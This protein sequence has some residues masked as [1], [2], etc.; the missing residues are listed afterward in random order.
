MTVVHPSNSGSSSTPA[1]GGFMGFIGL[2]V[3]GL[4]LWGFISALRILLAAT[5]FLMS[6]A[7]WDTLPGLAA[8]VAQ[9]VFFGLCAGVAVA[10][11]RSTVKTAAGVESFVS[12]LFNRRVAAPELDAHFFGQVALT[13]AIGIAVGYVTGAAGVTM[14]PAAWSDASAGVLGAATPIVAFAG[15]GFGGPGPGFWGV[16]MLILMI[17][18]LTLI[19]AALSS[20]LLH[21]ILLGM[22][23]AT[24]GGVRSYTT[25]L[26]SGDASGKPDLRRTVAQA[27]QRGFIVGGLMALIQGISTAVNLG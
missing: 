23:G 9:S 13:G 3:F 7:A 14:L 2:G 27:M 19:V 18:F 26:L 16:I 4:G 5:G 10:V 6:D 8:N 24:K 1:S 22:A 15:G 12:A 11:L 21:L 20:L 17:L 25:R